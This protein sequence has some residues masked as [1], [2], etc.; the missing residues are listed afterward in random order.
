MIC[1]VKKKS[2]NTIAIIIFC[3]C[4]GRVLLN[5]GHTIYRMKI[6]KYAI[7]GSTKLY[8]A[9]SFLACWPSRFAPLSLICSRVNG[10]LVVV[11]GAPT[12]IATILWIK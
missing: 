9:L 4:C 10:A 8:A 12:A 1:M 7:N 6:A 2:F 5:K 11:G 3:C